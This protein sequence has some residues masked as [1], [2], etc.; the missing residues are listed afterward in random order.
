MEIQWV[1]DTIAVAEA[2]AERSGWAAVPWEEL[3]QQM[4]AVASAEE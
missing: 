4:L 3:L 1:D 2:E